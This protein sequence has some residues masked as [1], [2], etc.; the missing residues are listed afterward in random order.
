MSAR[1][2][3][4]LGTLG[5]GVASSDALRKLGQL[6]EVVGIAACD[7]RTEAREAAER[8]YG[9]A[10]VESAEEV[11]SRDLAATYISTPT[12]AHCDGA[13]TAMGPVGG[14]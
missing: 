4:R 1:T 6:L 3:I 12:A 9:V 11:C 7:V 13:L 2:A 5:L 14:W 10:T 8:R